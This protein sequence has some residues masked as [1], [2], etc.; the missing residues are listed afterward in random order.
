MAMVT[1]R[2]IGSTSTL[3]TGSSCV[4]TITA[5]PT[6][7]TNTCG[8]LMGPTGELDANGNQTCGFSSGI[9]SGYGMA[10]IIGGG[11]LILLA[12]SGGK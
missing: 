11:L 10:V 3:C 2:G 7:T 1:L 6:P 8:F 12:L 4:T 9:G 5:T